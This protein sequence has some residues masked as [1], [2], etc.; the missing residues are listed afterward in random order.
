MCIYSNKN[1]PSGYY[2]YAYLRKNGTPYYIGKGIRGRAWGK[3]R[4]KIKDSEYLSGIQEPKNN[5]KI[6][7]L[8]S[9]LSEI[10]AFALERRMIRW[11]GRIDSKTGIL[12]NR[13][14]GGEGSVGSIKSDE[15]KK[16]M[17][18][19][20]LG[21]P[22]SESHKRNTSLGMMGNVPVNKGIRGVVKL[23]YRSNPT[24]HKFRHEDGTVE[25]CT[26]YDLWNKYNLEQ[27]NIRAVLAGRKKSC[28]GWRLIKE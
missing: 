4:Y 9:G 24:I 3:H 2:V 22:K 28:S 11:Y 23:P 18:T 10:G 6:V 15:T 1:H 13:T 27:S 14:D 26:M 7:I 25:I 21:I 12:R 5:T 20:S 8:E 19:S 16:K 17:S